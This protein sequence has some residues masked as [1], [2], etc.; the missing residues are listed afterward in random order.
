MTGNPFDMLE[1]WNNA[2]SDRQSVGYSHLYDRADTATEAAD[3][4]EGR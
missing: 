2:G 4:W 1:L 3:L